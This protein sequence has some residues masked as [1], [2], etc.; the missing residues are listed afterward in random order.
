MRLQSTGRSSHVC[1][2]LYRDEMV[3]GHRQSPPF[4]TIRWLLWP[5][6]IRVDCRQKEPFLRAQATCKPVQANL[7]RAK[8]GGSHVITA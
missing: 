6:Y 2:C 5:W 1:I 7:L 3:T 4:V 8:K